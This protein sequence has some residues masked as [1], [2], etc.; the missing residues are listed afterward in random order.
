MV[1]MVQTVKN[2]L[3][4]KHS[5]LDVDIAESI[6]EARA[7]MVRSGVSEEEANSNHP[8]IKAAIK[9]YCLAEYTSD[10]D[11]VEGYQKSWQYQLDNIRKS[12]MEEDDA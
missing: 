1:F 9:T 8:L 4:I 5:L 12:S 6:L 10:S 11:K 2:A 7:E 3:R